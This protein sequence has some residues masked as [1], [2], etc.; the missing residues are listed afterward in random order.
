MFILIG[1]FFFL[2]FF[3]GVLFLKYEQ[4][5]KK[6]EAG[7]TKQ[8]LYWQELQRL[9]VNAKTP[10]ELRYKPLTRGLQYKTWVL[11]TSDPFDIAIMCC[12][13]LNM[14]QMALDHEGASP[15]MLMFLKITNYIFT[16][17]FFVEAVLKMYV[18]RSAYF[19][20]GWNKFDF[21]V[22]FSSLIDLALEFMLPVPEGGQDDGG[23]QILSVGPQLA[24]VLRV[25][26]VSRVL[27]LAGKYK[28]L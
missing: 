17:V 9:I 8:Q 21:F 11:I 16:A 10:H 25:L 14:F 15:G 18:Y 20:T 28:G 19:K 22:V 23:S 3:I 24:R 2:N 7:F 4:A 5:Q 6:E 13:V 1:S 26:R 12:I 27:R